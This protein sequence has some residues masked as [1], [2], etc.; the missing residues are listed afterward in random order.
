MTA[1]YQSQPNQEACARFNHRPWRSA[2][3]PSLHIL[4]HFSPAPTACCASKTSQFLF[5]PSFADSQNLS[6]CFPV[7]ANHGLMISSAL[8]HCSIASRPQTRCE[9]S[10]FCSRFPPM[11]SIFTYP[12]HPRCSR[13][14]PLCWCSPRSLPLTAVSCTHLLDII[15]NS[16]LAKCSGKSCSVSGSEVHC[17]GLGLTTISCSGFPSSATAMSV[18]LL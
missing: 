10:A 7:R 6:V 17:E 1:V 15:S 14:L 13:R 4:S 3:V 5:R 16:T 9:S 11:A 8:L 18:L 2:Q 12:S